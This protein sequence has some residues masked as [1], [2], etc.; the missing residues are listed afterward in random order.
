MTAPG[1]A[2][3][4]FAR[5]GVHL[6]PVIQKNR[7]LL[8]PIQPVNRYL[9]AEYAITGLAHLLRSLGTPEPATIR[10]ARCTLCAS[11]E[12]EERSRT[13]E[14]ND[15]ARGNRDAHACFCLSRTALLAQDRANTV[16]IKGGVYNGVDDLEE[17]DTGANFAVSYN[18]YF[19]PNFALE[20]G[21][22][23]FSTEAT[24]SD[25][26]VSLGSFTEKDE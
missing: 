25:F 10:L 15:S 26:D 7:A 1:P 13:D 3:T 21:L 2:I 8:I 20:A 12:T 4:I 18:R 9:S 22:G 23:Y 6:P 17:G 14:K 11:P 5:L 24:F 16:S 19:S